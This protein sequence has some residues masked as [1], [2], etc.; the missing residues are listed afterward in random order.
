MMASL[1]YDGDNS[2]YWTKKTKYQIDLQTE[3]LKRKQ[4]LFKGGS[5]NV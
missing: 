5:D 4:L 2:L 1:I 3:Q